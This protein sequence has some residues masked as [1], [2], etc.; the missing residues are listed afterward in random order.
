MVISFHY[1]FS[2]LPALFFFKEFAKSFDLKIKFL[3]SVISLAKIKL[4][5]KSQLCKNKVKIMFSFHE[6]KSTNILGRKT[7]TDYQPKAKSKKQ[8]GW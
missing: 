3:C 7:Y 8:K 1:F 4:S 5:G 2:L 6:Q